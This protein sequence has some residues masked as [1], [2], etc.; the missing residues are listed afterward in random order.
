MKTFVIGLIAG[1][2]LIPVCGY[3]YLR[4]G[5]APVATAAPPLPMERSITHMAL[6]ARVD[7][8]APKSAPFVASEDDMKNAAHL[9]RAHC[10]VCHGIPGG[11]K[12]AIAKGMFP[13]PPVLLV[14]T[15]V[16]DDPA[17]ETF[18]KVANGIRLTGMPAFGQS[19]SAREMW[20]VSLMLAGADKLPASAQEILKAPLPAE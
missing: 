2:I 4:M 14:G 5:L 7:K 8:E 6:N 3:I 1:L 12:T 17:G 19:L 10:A 11:Q 18:W 16:T 15:G 9:Y 20:Q 13:K